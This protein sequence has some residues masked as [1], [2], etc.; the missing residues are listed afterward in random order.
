MHE[1]SRVKLK[2]WKSTWLAA[3]FGIAALSATGN[4]AAD[5]DLVR[6][7]ASAAKGAAFLFLVVVLLISP[8]A[9]TAAHPAA[10]EKKACV[11]APEQAV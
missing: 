11:P 2:A 5:L 10:A 4:A 9:P 1:F 8:H 7:I 6:S 3:R